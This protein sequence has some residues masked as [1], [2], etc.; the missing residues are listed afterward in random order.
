MMAGFA[1]GGKDRQ[2]YMFETQSI[3]GRHGKEVV[4]TRRMKLCWLGLLVF[5]IVYAITDS[6]AHPNSAQ[7]N[8]Q[9]WRDA[10]SEKSKRNREFD[11]ALREYEEERN[12][13]R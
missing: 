6:L 1:P 12:S 9:V 4:I 13:P 10:F 5:V 3:I 7:T 11:K 8:K 2:D